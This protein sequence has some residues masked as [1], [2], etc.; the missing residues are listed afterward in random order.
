M[1]RVL[2]S[3]LIA[4]GA[5]CLALPLVMA[6]ATLAAGKQQDKPIEDVTG[7]Y[8]FLS[9]DDTL[10]ILEEEGKLKGYVDVY[11]GEDESDAILSYPL[12]IGT[13]SGDHVEFKTGKI[14]E[15]YYR[16]SGTVERGKGRS[17]KD[18]DYLRLVGELQIIQTNSVTGQ[19]S[20]DKR[21]VIL[22]SKGGQPEEQ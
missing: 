17:M 11:Q 16:F 3:R 18:P 21:S 2:I 6:S 19:E 20:V 8:E 14:H 15:R 13:R 9:P 5:L 7:K 22:K 1:K 4:Q 10:A 12:S